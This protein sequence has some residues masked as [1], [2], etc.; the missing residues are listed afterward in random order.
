MLA[1]EQDRDFLMYFRIG[2]SRQR[3][4]A[5]RYF[6]EV[7]SDFRWTR[8]DHRCYDL[9]ESH[10]AVA[11]TL[12]FMLPFCK[13]FANDEISTMAELKELI[14]EPLKPIMKAFKERTNQTPRKEEEKLEPK[15]E[16]ASGTAPSKKRG[17]QDLAAPVGAAA[18]PAAKTKVPKPAVKE[19]I[20]KEAPPKPSDK[21]LIEKKAPEKPSDKENIEKKTTEKPAAKD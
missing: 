12:A 3:N 17:R 13:K 9:P 2:G 16:E 11:A 19:N 15:E 7:P 1:Q 4:M 20:E 14:K 10:P 5:I 21:D 6:G 18:E 8:E